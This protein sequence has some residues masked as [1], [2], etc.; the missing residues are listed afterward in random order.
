[1]H[2]KKASREERIMEERMEGNSKKE[3][4]MNSGMKGRWK[5][6][7]EVGRKEIKITT[8]KGR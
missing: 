8:D 6:K 4:A 5:I 3:E 2:R 1:M 7:H